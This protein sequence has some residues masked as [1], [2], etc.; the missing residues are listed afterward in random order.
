MSIGEYG[1][2]INREVLA[3]IAGAAAIEVAGVAG[4]S[5]APIS[6]NIG[7]KNPV[8]GSGTVISTDNGAIIVDVYVNLFQN[9]RVKTVA[10]EVQSNVKEKLQAMTGT[11]V[12]AVNVYVCRSVPEDNGAAEEEA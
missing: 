3:Q 2:E 1:L 10:E 5:N 12:V 8:N 11:P 4:L 9:A 7:I 6:K